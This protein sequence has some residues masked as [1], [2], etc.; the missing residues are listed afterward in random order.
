MPIFRYWINLRVN[1]EAARKG[2]MQTEHGNWVWH[3][4]L[5]ESLSLTFSWLC[6]L[7]SVKP[8]GC[9]EIVLALCGDC[10]LRESV[11]I[12]HIH[13]SIP[14]VFHSVVDFF[15]L[16]YARWKKGS[17]ATP[18]S[19]WLYCLDLCKSTSVCVQTD[20]WRSLVYVPVVS[21][22]VII[23][24]LRGLNVWKFVSCH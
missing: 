24:A 12:F 4:L 23:L 2:P 10:K 1:I 7:A 22:N 6:V 21:C 16:F 11:T 20:C 3:I 5:Y 9:L 18:F 14:S 17:R 15:S 8:I 19:C 13:P